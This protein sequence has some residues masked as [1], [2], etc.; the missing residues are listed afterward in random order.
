[1]LGWVAEKV[2]AVFSDFET[3]PLGCRRAILPEE[4]DSDEVWR[5]EP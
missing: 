5:G 3:M 2:S 4:R 1:M